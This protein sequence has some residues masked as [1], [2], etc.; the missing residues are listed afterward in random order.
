[1]QILFTMFQV[2]YFRTNKSMDAILKGFG[3]RKILDSDPSLK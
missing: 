1:M 2:A 3:Y